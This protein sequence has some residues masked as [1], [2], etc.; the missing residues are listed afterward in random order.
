MKLARRCLVVTGLL[1]IG[2]PTVDAATLTYT[3]NF[4]PASP[5]WSNSIGNWTSSGGQYNAQAPSNSPETYSGL[6]FDFANSNFSLTV[7][8]NGLRDGGIW[9][10]TDGSRN[11]GILFVA[12]GNGQQ[13]NWAYW[14]TFENGIHSD[15]LNVNH[16]AFTP[17]LTYTL[18]ILISGNTYQAYMDPNGILDASSV[19]LT[20]LI[21]NT[22]SHGNV[23]L[24]DFFSTTTFSNFSVTGDIYNPLAVPG[25]IPGTGLPGLIIAGIGMLAWGGREPQVQNSNIVMRSDALDQSIA[26]ERVESRSHKGGSET[27]ICNL[28]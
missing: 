27:F 10:N 8:V 4:S 18:T 16:N 25:P 14:H 12:G 21:D 22:Y 15:P 9:L 23:G 6:P 2:T 1:L 5:L 19:L 11:N 7:T 20:T 17:D 24:Y 3:D 26:S 28:N 13:G